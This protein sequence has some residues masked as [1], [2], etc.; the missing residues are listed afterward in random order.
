M[1]VIKPGTRDIELGVRTF[2]LKKMSASALDFVLDK[3]LVS[4]EDEALKTIRLNI[5]LGE[6]D[7]S[8]GYFGMLKLV[9][10]PGMDEIIRQEAFTTAPDF[11]LDAGD[12]LEV[13]GAWLEFSDFGG[14][15]KKLQAAGGVMRG[16]QDGLRALLGL[17]VTP[18]QEPPSEP[19]VD[20]AEPTQ[21]RK[22]GKSR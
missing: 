22:S 4:N 21:S 16:A 9:A 15:L 13:A 1:S 19:S 20:A 18:S 8:V 12:L 10:L 17:S 11:E 7:F 6:T 2:Q 14:L 5:L 3:I